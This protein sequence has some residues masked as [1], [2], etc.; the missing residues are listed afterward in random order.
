MPR[1]LGARRACNR[2]LPEAVN[3]R[4]RSTRTKLINLTYAIN[5]ILHF[6]NGEFCLTTL[7]HCTYTEPQVGE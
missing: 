5:P 7:A 1:C 6:F 3:P 2:E 4:L